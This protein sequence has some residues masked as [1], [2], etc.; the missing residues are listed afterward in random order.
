ML[1]PMGRCERCIALSAA[2]ER[3]RRAEDENIQRTVKKTL[4]DGPRGIDDFL[5]EHPQIPGPESRFAGVRLKGEQPVKLSPLRQ[6]FHPT[7]NMADVHRNAAEPVP[8]KESMPECAMPFL[9]CMCL[10]R[11]KSPSVA[12]GLFVVHGCP[13]VS[14]R[15][16]AGAGASCLSGGVCRRHPR[17]SPPPR[18][19]CG[20][21]R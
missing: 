16:P 8:D 17:G 7:C 19:A 14:L 1:F 4:P 10:F 6:V 12:E 5:P 2:D 13:A 21:S 20:S 11:Q 9:F 3:I 15:Y 18:P